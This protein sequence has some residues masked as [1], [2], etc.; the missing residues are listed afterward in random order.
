MAN[1]DPDPAVQWLVLVCPDCRSKFRTRESPAH[2][3]ARCPRCGTVIRLAPTQPEPSTP[4]SVRPSRNKRPARPVEAE[5]SEDAPYAAHGPEAVRPFDVPDHDPVEDIEVRRKPPPAPI[6]PLWWGVYGFPWHAS[7]LRAWFLFGIGLTL[8]AVLG[9]AMNYVLDL[10]QASDL[11]RGGIWIRVLILYTKGFVLFLLWTG[12]YAGSFFLATIQE[13]AAGNH[14][15]GWPDDSFWE[16]FFTFFS[17]VWIFLCAAVPFGIAVTPWQPLLG[18]GVYGWSL[19]PSTVLVFPIVL[20][21]ALANNSLW[22]FWN[23]DVL[24]NLLRR[25]HVLLLVYLMSALL[26]APCVAL[27]RL[28]ILDYGQFL[29]LAPVTG[30]VWSACLLIYGRLLGRL[31]WIITGGQELAAREAR[32]RRRRKRR[33]AS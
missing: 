16:K 12:A 1:E 19:V 10:Y 25:P 14:E 17:L 30:F 7:A 4:E 9:G 3:T 32:R 29:F 15:V 26:L 21:C 28:T 20:L 13:T 8:V 24:L 22:L 5:E 2:K 23:A 27:G 11:G 33:P 18:F 31:A 6:A